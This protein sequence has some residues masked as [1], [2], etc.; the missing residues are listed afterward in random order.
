MLHSAMLIELMEDEVKSLQSNKH[1]CR[2]GCCQH[3]HT[4]ST[5]K[6]DSR[7]HPQASCRRQTPYSILIL[8]EDD[9]TST[10]ETDTT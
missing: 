7:R 3:I 9:R 6:S 1:E 2:S 8:L 4:T 5:S 10:N